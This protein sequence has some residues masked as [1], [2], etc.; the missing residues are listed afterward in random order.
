M[1]EDDYTRGFYAGVD[2]GITMGK[3]EEREAILE[4]IE[5]HEGIP[6]NV[7][8]IANEIQGRYKKDQA[9]SL[10]ELGL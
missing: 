7:Q 10:R 3:R 9:E 5:A 1:K 4:F 2:Q 6:I 8:D